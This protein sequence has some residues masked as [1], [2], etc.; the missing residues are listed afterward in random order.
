MISKTGNSKRNACRNLHRLLR[1][2]KGLFPVDVDVAPITVAVR[3]PVYRTEQVWWPMVPLTS[4]V[5]ALWEQAPTMLLG[6]HSSEDVNGWQLTMLQFWRRFKS[7]HE[8]HPIFAD[9]HDLKYAIPYMLHGD[10]GRGQSRRSF[11]VEAW[12]P[13]ISHKGINFTNE[14]G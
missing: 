14:S 11:M 12:Q 13:C 3:K 7:F 9:G 1:R 6:G 5:K 10:E 4:W 8:S 2:N